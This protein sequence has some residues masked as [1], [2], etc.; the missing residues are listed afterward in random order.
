MS[1]AEKVGRAFIYLQ[2]VAVAAAYL[3]LVYLTDTLYVRR[4]VSDGGLAFGYS[5]CL[6]EGGVVAVLLALSLVIKFVR[7]RRDARWARVQPAI[8]AQISAHMN[9]T[10]CVEELRRLGRRYPREV[11]QCVAEFL[12]RVRGAAS[13]RLTELA[14]D[15]GLVESRGPAD[16]LAILSVAGG[17]LPRVK[18]GAGPARGLA[19]VEGITQ[20]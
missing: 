15:L 3:L 7:H 2:A 18:L 12:L 9:R 14:V 8:T 1:R 6:A 11:D 4:H 20:A 13:E 19:A 10:N 16:P 17:A 5:F